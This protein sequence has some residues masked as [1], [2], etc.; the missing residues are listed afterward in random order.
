M[1][2]SIDA[3]IKTQRPPQDYSRDTAARFGSSLVKRDT[4]LKQD[5]LHAML[6]LERRRAERSRKP[7]VLMLIDS[8]ALHLNG[9]TG[10]FADKLA[11]TVAGA[12]RETDIIGW[13]EEFSTLAVI[14]TEINADLDVSIPDVL[15]GKVLKALDDAF[16]RKLTSSLVVSVHTFPEKI[17]SDR[18]NR[19]TDTR[20][21]PDLSHKTSKKRGSM[22][23]K[24]AIDIL[25]SAALLLVL[26]PILLLITLIIKLTSKGPVL[27]AQERL[28]QYGR[29][30]K[31]LKFRS[32]YANNDPKIHREFV[33]KFIAG[34]NSAEKTGEAQPA[35]FKIT[36][37]PR[38]T[39]IGKFIRK[40]SLDEF[41]QF[42]N[43]LRGEM[44]LVG[45]RPPVSYEYDVYDFWHRRRVLEVKPGVTGLWQVSGRSRTSFDDMVRL[46][47][48]YSQTWSI[49]LDLRILFAT[50]R[51][52]L[53]GDGA[54]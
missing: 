45:P 35:V 54:F 43:V 48:R 22:I 40:T 26:S 5:A 38:V 44:S 42:I 4:I 12:T 30:F 28:G 53:G 32:M 17:D 37:D 46:D 8:H 11:S 49:W 39:P 27:F 15:H 52:V 3:G 24:R 16:D 47:L 25:G 31:C 34:Q 10:A 6:T 18:E 7:F 13:Y 19:S 51:A 29:P 23:V 41:P 9:Q 21:F 36:N 20:L 2:N 1:G 50:P 14:F 33:Q